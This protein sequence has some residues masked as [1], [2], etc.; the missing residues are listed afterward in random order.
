MVGEREFTPLPYSVA[1]QQQDACGLPN[2]I[3]S[4]GRERER[5]AVQHESVYLKIT[6]KQVRLVFMQ[7]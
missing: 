6:C 3:S 2:T 7:S 5:G 1:M 4:S